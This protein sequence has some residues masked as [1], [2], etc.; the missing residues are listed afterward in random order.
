MEG[1]IEMS[2]I[3]AMCVFKDIVFFYCF[4]PQQSK[5]QKQYRQ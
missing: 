2:V 5:C 3:S 1:A 4:Q